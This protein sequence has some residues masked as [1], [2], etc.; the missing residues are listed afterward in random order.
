MCTYRAP[1]LLALMA[2]PFEATDLLAASVSEAAQTKALDLREA[3]S[4]LRE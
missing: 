3:Y 2:D 4:R 1:M